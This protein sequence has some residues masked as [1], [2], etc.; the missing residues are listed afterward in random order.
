MLKPIRQHK[1]SVNGYNCLKLLISLLGSF[2]MQFV[3]STTIS[4]GTFSSQL[5]HLSYVL[6]CQL[7]SSNLQKTLFYIFNFTLFPSCKIPIFFYNCKYKQ[8]G[9]KSMRVGLSRED[10]LCRSTW[11]VG[12][13][14]IATRLR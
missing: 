9:E 7:F 3:T 5:I 6:P 11:I 14:L 13:N 4:P 2:F 10:A 12:V 8:V 1:A